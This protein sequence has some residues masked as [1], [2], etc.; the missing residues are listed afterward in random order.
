MEE[1]SYAFY[2]CIYMGRQENDS[3]CYE[4]ILKVTSSFKSIS[5]SKQ[6]NLKFA[7]SHSNIIPNS[8]MQIVVKAGTI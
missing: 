8:Q 6:I 4:N 1:K 2:T 7:C 5:I 3:K